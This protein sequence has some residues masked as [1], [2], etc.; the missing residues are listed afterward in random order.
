MEP[1]E[2]PAAT[3][4]APPGLSLP[5]KKKSG[6][7]ALKQHFEPHLEEKEWKQLLKEGKL[8]KGILR[9]A[10]NKPSVAYVQPDGC[11][12]RENDIVVNGRAAR[13]RAVHGDVVVIE[14]IQE[15]DAALRARKS[16]EE[17]EEEPSRTL[18]TEVL[19]E[20]ESSDDSDEEVIF[21]PNMATPEDILAS[22]VGDDGK[23]RGKGSR[24]HRGD[25]T[26]GLVR[27]LVDT[28][29][30]RDRVR[31]CTLH[32]NT[33]GRPE[34]DKNSDIV[35]EGDNVIRAVPTDSKY[36]W[37][38]IQVNAVS[39][40]I[41]SIPGHL[42]RFKL[43]PVE[44]VKWND[45][46]L[47]PLGRLK[48]EC[49]GNAGEV[50][51]EEKHALIEHQLDDHDVDFTDEEIAEVKEIV[52]HANT[53]FES[54]VSRRTD[55][56]HKRIFTIDPASARDLDDAIHVDEVPG[57]REV[58]IGVH[59]ADVGHFLKLGSIADK[60]AQRRATSVYLVNRVLPMLPHA[61]CNVLCSLNPDDAKVSF[62]AF[63]RLNRETGDLVPNSSRFEK[64]VMSSA[65]RLNYDQAQMILDGEEQEIDPKPFVREPHTWRQIQRDI[66]LLQDVCGK[67]R[68]GRL[69]NG[70]MTIT[71]AKMIFHTRD[72]PD[73]I[74]TGYHLEDH[75]AS[76]WIIEEL[77]LLANRVV[78][79]HLYNSS[80]SEVAVLRNHKPPDAKKAEGLERMMKN[81]LNIHD[82]DASSAGAV[83]K[84]CK[85]IIAKYG[86]MLGRCVEMLVMRCGMLQAEYFVVGDKED[87]PHHYAL[88]FDFYTHFTSPIR[89]YPDVMVHRVLAALLT[90]EDIE[91]QDRQAAQEQV[92]ICNEK[93]TNS[94]RCQEQ[95]DRSMFCIYL[96]AQKEWFYTIGTVLSFKEDKKCGLDVI[97]VYV[98]QLGKEKKV[99]MCSMSDFKKLDLY[100]STDND[101]LL[102]PERWKFRGK[103]AATLFWKDPND[104]EKPERPQKLQVFS[105]IPM[106]II[107]TNTVPIDYQMF[108]VSPF[109][110]EFDPV[111]TEVP[112]AAAEGFAWEESLEEGVE[113]VHNADAEE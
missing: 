23:G 92:A 82:W 71:R 51:A 102:L 72:T 41:L 101:K 67:V 37:M 55:L 27:A 108:F 26:M 29:N 54:E 48:G 80:M 28:K 21:K 86:E 50:E 39:K 15:G 45:N 32:P 105:C 85:K 19:S 52:K 53:S 11:K 17:I 20:D 49:L 18:Q 6:D 79:E 99:L 47:L 90:G 66:F 107:P 104:P 88:N 57:G 76:H 89:R 64:T 10:P 42:D 3:S 112:E 30:G 100:I 111:A 103:G 87:S 60:E 8:I 95:L 94:R 75:S 46:S 81:N 16:T 2:T 4:S 62:S 7:V 83:Y 40:N 91:F 14:I 31:V 77:M 98:S 69:G 56:R 33:H 106:V 68:Q 78:A 113:V 63:F 70:A 13:N 110:K 61:L 22:A 24:G 109:H 44:L 93:K 36:P 12:P 1:S 74:P 96:R 34:E 84:S 97:T 25:K 38:L 73:G 43:W 5:E 65:C 58:E 59:I 35:L 9:V